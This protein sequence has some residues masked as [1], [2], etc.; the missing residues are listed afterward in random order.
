M[1]HLML[2]EQLRNC[3]ENVEK[4]NVPSKASVRNTHNGD[5]EAIAEESEPLKEIDEE[6]DL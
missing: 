1:T 6:D 4:G 3:I 5:I 2:F